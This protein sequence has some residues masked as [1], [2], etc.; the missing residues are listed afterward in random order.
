MI[1]NEAHNSPR[2][3]AFALA[4]AKALRPLGYSILA[5]EGFASD[6]D[7]AKLE[8]MMK[9]LAADKYPRLKTG[10]YL[11]D[12]VFG[13]FVRQSLALGYRPVAYEQV[14]ANRALSPLEQISAREQAQAENLVQRI[15]T[16]DR[17]A[18]VLIYVGYS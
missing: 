1:L 5:A 16:R 8:A 7:P 9:M 2:D 17:Q 3:R 6:A 11:R 18:K 12:P 15:F 13:D 4:V 14:G 10:F